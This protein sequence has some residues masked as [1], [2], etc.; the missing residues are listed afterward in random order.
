VNRGRQERRDDLERLRVF[1]DRAS[2]IEE[3]TL[4]KER[5]GSSLNVRWQR[6]SP[7]VWSTREPSGEVLEPLLLRLR[8]MVA[9]GSDISI[10]AI[11]NVCEGR[12]SHAEM[13]VFL[14]DVR[15]AWTR[16]QRHGII[17]LRINERDMSPER[18]ADLMINGYYFHA[19]PANRAE[20][21]ALVGPAAI[22][23][24][25]VF[26]DYIYRAVDAVYSTADVVRIGLERDL[27]GAP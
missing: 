17:G 5:I 15:A 11:H 21:E 1:G 20:L 24:R 12:L 27:F 26:I 18:A 25:Q 10:F 19:E 23:T 8:P 2:R 14:H 13:R 6:G 16:S 4:V 7:V 9:P 3:S 22:L